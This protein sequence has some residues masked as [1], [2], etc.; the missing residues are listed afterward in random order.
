M[1]ILIVIIGVA[2]WMIY[3]YMRAPFYD[4]E[5]KMFYKKRKK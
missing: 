5:T 4:E 1:E 2:A 3:E